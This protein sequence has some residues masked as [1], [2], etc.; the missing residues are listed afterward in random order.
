MYD[1]LKT[2]VEIMYAS[3]DKLGDKTF[4]QYRGSDNK[5]ISISYNSFVEMVE[6]LSGT[7]YEYGLRKG[8]R[9]GIISDNMYKWLIADMAI[10]SLGAA[11]VPRGSDSTP[12][13]VSYILSHSE[14]KFCFTESPKTADMVLSTIQL[15]PSIKRIFLFTG[16]KDEITEKI[17]QDII[18]ETFDEL[19]EKGKSLF[20]KNK[21]DIEKT[22][23]VISSDDLVTLIYTSGTTGT[24][25]GVMLLNKNIMH[26]LHVLPDILPVNYKDR[27]VSILPV[28][29]VFERTVEYCVMITGGSMAYSKPTAKHLLPDLAEIRPTFMVSVPRVWQSVYNGVISKIDK[30]SAVSRTL[31]YG[32]IKI[33]GAFVHLKKIFLNQ[34]PRYKKDNPIIA[35]LKML[36]SLTG[37]IYL[38][39]LFLLGDL[40]VF[41]KVRAKTGGKLKGPISGGGALPPHVDNFFAVIGVEILEG[42]GLTETSPVV[43]VRTFPRKVPTTIGRPIP[44]CQLMIGDDKFQPINSQQE[45]G[46][47]YIKGDL[48]MG[49][50]YKSPD[51]TAEVINSEGWFNSG[52]LGMITVTGEL[53]LCGRAKDTIVLIGGE[54]IEPEPIEA[55]LLEDQMINQVIVAGQDQKVLSALICPNEERL[56]DYAKQNG[57]EYISKNDLIKNP[58]IVAEY[59]RICKTQTS[60][61]NG[62]KSYEKIQFI[63]LLEDNFEVGKEITN[64]LKL[65]RN[66][67]F[68]KYKKEIERMYRV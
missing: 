5:F 67:I 54:N 10:L 47:V 28:W 2:L 3:R 48:V 68:E 44:G 55:K 33:G 26:N 38:L 1:Q 13:E 34:M 20:N 56:F 19:L 12:S 61:K 17:P 36:L 58:K 62:F 64:S 31:F 14:S 9:V 41:R 27:W 40:L 59:D 8:D 21:T 15:T 6:Y 60:T 42:Y 66:V 22:R 24:P 7:L 16:N 65:K 30:G 53:H 4:L 43:G 11:D 25:K 45:K 57:I 18:V 29:H 46:I 49:G 23:N 35:F 63:T 37:L 52:D 39:P 32:F 50:Y 51:K